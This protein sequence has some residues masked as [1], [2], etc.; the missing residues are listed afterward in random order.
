MTAAG[1]DSSAGREALESLCKKYWSPLYAFIRRS[2]K[3]PHDAEDLTQA[4]F[5]FIVKGDLL[6]KATPE[7]GRF[8]SFLLGS[9]KHFIADAHDR[10]NALKRG[11]R[12]EFVPLPLEGSYSAEP[13]DALSPE[14][15]FERRWAMTLL[16]QARKRLEDEYTA[17]GKASFYREL[18]LF[19]AADAEA[20]SYAVTAARLSIPENTLKS[21]VRRL[22]LRY[23]E[24]LRE[25]ISQTV[26]SPLEVDEEIQ[27]L[28]SVLA[29]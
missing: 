13:V 14:K 18:S 11:G 1:Q 2:G 12:T 21:G 26:D 29:N 4:F 3:S 17:A 22:R 10:A 23:R 15:L 19:N 5:G 20:P 16:S 9:L 24:L 28:L 27:Y 25:E 6:R 7:R 8:R